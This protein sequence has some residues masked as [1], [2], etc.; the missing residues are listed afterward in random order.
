MER[1]FW[2]KVVDRGSIRIF[3]RK[4]V[5]ACLDVFSGADD[6]HIDIIKKLIIFSDPGS[7]K[8]IYKI[9]TNNYNHTLHRLVMTYQVN[10]SIYYI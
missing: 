6:V 2:L 1:W 3:F 4:R 8:K 7:T 9:L 10:S 5:Y